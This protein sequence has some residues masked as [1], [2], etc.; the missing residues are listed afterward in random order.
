LPN[1]QGKV[2]DY[3]P[4]DVMQSL[5]RHHWPGNIRELQNFIERAVIMSSGPNLHLPSE[6]LKRM[7]KRDQPTAIRTL[8]ET[9]RDHILEVLQLVRGVVGGGTA[10]PPCLVCLAQPCSLGCVNSESR[11]RAS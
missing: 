11:E 1:D 2:I 8:A 4:Y 5:K 6:E 7:I 3:I 9:E 10:P